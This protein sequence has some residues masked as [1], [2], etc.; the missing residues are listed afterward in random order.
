MIEQPAIKSYFFGKGIKD[1]INTI[2]DGLER[3]K[4]SGVMLFE[5]ATAEDWDVMWQRE[6][7]GELIKAL[8]Q[9]VA[10]AAVFIFGFMAIGLLSLLHILLLGIVFMVMYSIFTMLWLLEKGYKFYNKIFVPCPVCYVKSDLPVYHCPKCFREH[11]KLQPGEYGI[12]KRTCICGEQLSTSILNGRNQLE[13]SCP[14]CK[15][16]ITGKE[17]RPI[18]IPLIGGAN[19]GKT[20][21]MYAAT[22]QLVEKIA[23]ERT[24]E[25]TFATENEEAD[26]RHNSDLL[27]SGSYPMKTNDFRPKGLGL[28][29]KLPHSNLDRTLYVFDPAGEAYAEAHHLRKHNF[30]EYFHGAFLTIDALTFGT[31]VKENAKIGAPPETG[32]KVEEIISRIRRNLEKNFN[33]KANDVVKQPVAVLITKADIPVIAEA[34]PELSDIDLLDAAGRAFLVKHGKEGLIQSLSMK[35]K[36]FKIFPVSAKGANAKGLETPLLWLLSNIDKNLK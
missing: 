6:D 31:I 22:T 2:K 13:A 7:Y 21:F 18:V 12:L 4:A 28:Q 35:F 9:F 16:S 1:L 23:A 24:W 30:Y 27:K 20:S 26:Y 5:D 32:L 19:T 11:T 14:N 36:Y 3:N 8:I 34:F 15:K 25:L 17:T 29:I 33:V 10:A